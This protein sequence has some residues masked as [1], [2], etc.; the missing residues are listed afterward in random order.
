M[1]KNV[2]I[3][4]SIVQDLISYT[5]RFPRPGESVRGSAFH[6]GAGGKGANQAVAA[7]RLGANVTMIGMV[8]KDMFGDSNIESLRQNGV[9]TSGVGRSQEKHTATATITVNQEAENSIVVTLGANLDLLPEFAD[10][11]HSLLANSHLVLCQGEIPEAANRR[12]FEIARGNGAKTFLNP[13][14]GDAKMDKSILS[15]TDIVCTNENEAEFITGI[16]QTTLEDAENAARKMLEMGPQIAIITLG[17]KGVLLAQTLNSKP[18]LKLIPVQKV[19]AIDTT[20]AG[21]CFCGSL[22]ALLSLDGNL[23]NVERATR[24]AAKLAALSVTRRGTQ[25]SYWKKGEILEKFP[26]FFEE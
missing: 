6:A 19:E 24:C 20:G 22:A 18:D 7:A 5:E 10:K 4:G 13:A 16:P 23:E 15:L 11:S 3:F 12:A 8:G 26:G 1:S 25:A 2:V 17:A 9:D 14:P 21:D